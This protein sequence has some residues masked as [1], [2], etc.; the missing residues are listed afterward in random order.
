MLEYRLISDSPS[1]VQALID[2]FADELSVH[3]ELQSLQIELARM[4]I[5]EGDLERLMDVLCSLTIRPHATLKLLCRD[6]PGCSICLS[7]LFFNDATSLF[8]HDT[9]AVITPA[10]AR[11]IARLLQSHP[12]L[13]TLS[14]GEPATEVQTVIDRLAAESLSA[15][16]RSHSALRSIRFHR[17]RVLERA[18]IE[19]IAEALVSNPIMDELAFVRPAFKENDPLPV[20]SIRELPT[21]IMYDDDASSDA[22]MS[23][24]ATIL[25]TSTSLRCLYLDLHEFCPRPDFLPILFS[26]ASLQSLGVHHHHAVFVPFSEDACRS[27]MT[28]ERITHFE[29]ECTIEDPVSYLRFCKAMH[30]NGTIIH[31]KFAPKCLA[32]LFRAGLKIPTP[33]HSLERNICNHRMHSKTL[34]EMLL[35]HLRDDTPRRPFTRNLLPRR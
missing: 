22:L 7:F 32:T 28:N 23:D 29:L 5:S 8:V 6:N 20:T 33:E 12:Q 10:T 19:A 11:L 24:F 9:G 26:A 31:M 13:Q 25:C 1:T 17:I 3:P 16:F 35:P 21:P 4:V 34:F 18:S 15:V 2:I 30:H 27:L 14:L